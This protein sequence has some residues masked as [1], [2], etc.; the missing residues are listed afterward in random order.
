MYIY[1]YIEPILGNQKNFFFFEPRIF[2]FQKLNINQINFNIKAHELDYGDSIF[3]TIFEN[4]CK[5]TIEHSKNDTENE[6]E[7]SMELNRNK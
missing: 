2:F 1:L 3:Y 5:N 7:L 4:I 6:L